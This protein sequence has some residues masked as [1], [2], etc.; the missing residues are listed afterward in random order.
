MPT[1]KSPPKKHPDRVSILIVDEN[2]MA[3]S[4]WKKILQRSGQVEIV[5]ELAL[6]EIPGKLKQTEPPEVIVAGN[7]YAEKGFLHN[8]KVKEIW[9]YFPKTLVICDKPQQVPPAFKAHA[10]L[11]VCKPFDDQELVTWVRMISD[12]AKRLCEEY[13]GQL[14]SNS[15]KQKERS[16]YLKLILSILQLLFHPDLVNPESVDIRDTDALSNDRLVFRNQAKKGKIQGNGALNF[17]EF[18]EDMRQDH[19]AKYIPID[20]YNSEVPSQAIRRMASYLT[21]SHSSFGLVIGR[22]KDLFKLRS[23]Q[24]AQLDNE[25][26]VI[27]LLGHSDLQ[28]M[29][30]YKAGGINPACL[31]KIQYQQLVIKAGQ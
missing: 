30:E 20:I 9:G 31:L 14:I 3:R 18:W 13:Y 29:L 19:N 16:G 12:E 11:A 26:K 1:K 2:K 17:D 10:D 6:N 27:L 28:E 21:P 8:A 5:G 7:S 22:E 4:A 25:E 15:A 23:M 24:V